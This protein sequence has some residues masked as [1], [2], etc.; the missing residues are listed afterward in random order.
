MLACGSGAAG[1]GTRNVPFASPV[2][3]AAAQLATPATRSV[4]AL[5]TCD[6]AVRT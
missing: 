5:V 3:A 1:V 6:V 2:L 4:K